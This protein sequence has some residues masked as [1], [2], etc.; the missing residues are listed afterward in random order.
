M[1]A[2]K[3]TEVFIEEICKTL[4]EKHPGADSRP[5]DTPFPQV[6]LILRRRQ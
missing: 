2:K 4:L 6:C 3:K 1:K 5:N